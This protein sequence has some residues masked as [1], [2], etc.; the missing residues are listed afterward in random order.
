MK[1]LRCD[2]ARDLLLPSLHQEDFAQETTHNQVASRPSQ[3]SFISSD[4]FNS[5]YSDPENSIDYY[6][7]QTFSWS[8]NEYSLF[9][10]QYRH[11]NDVQTRSRHLA[12]LPCDVLSRNE[13]M[14][15]SP[16]R[17]LQLRRRQAVSIITNYLNHSPVEAVI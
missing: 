9:P 7:T 8:R 11:R 10:Q 3:A 15:L 4:P 12:M 13:K 14:L 6:T 2:M 5:T 17:R 1:V 16:S